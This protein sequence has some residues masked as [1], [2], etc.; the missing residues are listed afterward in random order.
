MTQVLVGVF[1]SVADANLAIAALTE[2]GIAREDMEVHSSERTGET[3]AEGTGTGLPVHQPTQGAETGIGGLFRR[4]F[5]KDEQSA[6]V[7]HYR[8]VVRRGGVVLAVTVVDEAQ[9]ANVRA[10]LEG[11]GAIDV[12]EP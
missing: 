4:F 10:T 12:G 5:G 8:E 6:Q 9:E 7:E 11:T 1:D 3:L 2:D